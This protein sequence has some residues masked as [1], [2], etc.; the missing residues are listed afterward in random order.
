MQTSEGQIGKGQIGN[1]QIAKNQMGMGNAQT[2]SC[3]TVSIKTGCKLNLF[4]NI[5]CLRQDGYHELETLFYPLAQ[6]FDELIIEP[7]NTAG[8]D[9]QCP[10]RPGLSAENTTL[11]KA[12]SAFNLAT[13]LHLGFKLCLH[14][15][16]PLGAGL[17]GGSANAAGFLNYLN[18]QAGDKA[19]PFA[20]LLKVAAGVGADVPFFLQNSPAL[21]TG[22]GENLTTVPVNLAGKWLVL[23]YPGVHVSTPWAYAQWDKLYAATQSGT[24]PQRNSKNELHTYFYNCLTSSALTD[25]KPFLT[26]S[27]FYNNLEDAV[28]P[29]FPE[30]AKIKEKLLISGARAALMS[31]SG[32]TI[33]GLFNTEDQARQAVNLKDLQSYNSLVQVL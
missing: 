11:H 21:A 23:I 17:G 22:I 31:G 6:P 13:G 33:F 9:L 15:Q 19:L 8:L 14:K 29:A 3:R 2:S 30:L 27:W 26:W 16:V 24:L 18:T 1:D 10:I 12:L 5:C 25:K 20:Q 32:S 7:K 28:F 4:L